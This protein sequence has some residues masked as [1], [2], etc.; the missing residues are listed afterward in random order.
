M[1]ADVDTILG[2]V[3]TVTGKEYDRAEISEE[4]SLLD[5]L[6]LTSIQTVDMIMAIEEKFDVEIEDV[7][8][9]KLRTFGQIIAY[10]NEK[11]S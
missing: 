7:D 9:D 6:A 11:T 2:L 5:D 3:Q 10:I 8:L 1:T 4:T